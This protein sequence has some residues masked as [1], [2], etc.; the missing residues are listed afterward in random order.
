M[1]ISRWVPSDGVIHKDVSPG[2]EEQ[3]ALPAVEG[4][5]SCWWRAV[6]SHR[7]PNQSAQHGEKLHILLELGLRKKHQNWCL[8]SVLWVRRSILVPGGFCCRPLPSAQSL[9]HGTCSQ[10]PLEQSHGAPSSPVT[11]RAPCLSQEE[12]EIAALWWQRVRKS[13]NYS[14]CSM[15]GDLKCKKGI[16]G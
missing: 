14:R 4:A 3:K 8:L 7:A 12:L 1:C 13:W 15:C 16:P 5:D 11:P 6:C 10:N 2:E 9:L